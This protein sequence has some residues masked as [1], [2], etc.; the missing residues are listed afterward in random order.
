MLL[1][2]GFSFLIIFPS[3]ILGEWNGKIKIKE[4]A[5]NPQEDVA[6][7]KYRLHRNNNK[8]TIYLAGG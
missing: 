1:T 3:I 8:K 7:N 2:S 4:N 5:N 6:R